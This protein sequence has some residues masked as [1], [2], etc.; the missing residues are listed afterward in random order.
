MS[1]N[2]EKLTGA[3]LKAMIALDQF[4]V[5]EMVKKI[6]GVEPLEATEFMKKSLRDR[7][8]QH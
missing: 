3:A 8:G 5:D 1:V 4:L 7:Y 6:I 2:K